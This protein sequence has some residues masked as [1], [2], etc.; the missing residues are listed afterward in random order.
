MLPRAGAAARFGMI[1]VRLRLPVFCKTPSARPE[2]TC[3][4]AH[5][6]ILII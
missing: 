4:F 6:Q 3:N 5:Y 2:K 1:V